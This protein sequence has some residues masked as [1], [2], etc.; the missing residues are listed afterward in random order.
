MNTNSAADPANP[1]RC[2]HNGG[3]YVTEGM[4]VHQQQL[5]SGALTPVL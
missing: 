4:A 2:A 1:K 3:E 5:A